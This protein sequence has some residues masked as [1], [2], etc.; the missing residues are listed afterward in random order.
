MIVKTGCETDGELHSSTLETIAAESRV[1]HHITVTNGSTSRFTFTTS[2]SVPICWGSV[3][4]LN[5]LNLFMLLVINPHNTG[6]YLPRATQEEC[7][8]ISLSPL[9]S[10]IRHAASRSH[11]NLVLINTISWSLTIVINIIF[12]HN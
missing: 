10:T 1:L 12:R 2:K 4:L 8:Q 9:S 5:P 7:G 6:E 11:T 3:Y